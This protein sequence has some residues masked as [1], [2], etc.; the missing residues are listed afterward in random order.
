MNYK[1]DF[2]VFKNRP[3]MIYLDNAASSLKPDVVTDAVA[4][5]YKN[6]SSN[7]ERGLYKTGLEATKIVEETREKVANF[8]GA[9]SNEVIFT[10]GC[11]DSL[12][13]V[14]IS[15][16]SMINEGDE[17]ISSISEHHSSFLPWL[18]VAKEKKAIIKFIPLTADGKIT[19]DNFKT[20]LSSKTKIVA[21]AQTT[22]V[23]GYTAPIKEIARLAHEV[24]AIVS[25]DG[26]Q[27]IPHKRIDVKDLDVDLYSF[28]FH[29]M[30]GPTG[31]GI[32]YGKEKVLN[33]M[34]PAELGGEMNDE[35][36]LSS[37][38]YKEIP[39]KFEAGTLPIAEIFGAGACIDYLSKIGYEYIEKR[40]ITLAKK[41]M[42]ELK[43]IP[44]IIIYN[45]KEETPI[46]SFNI[47]G[48]HS[49]DSVSY[50]AEHDVCMRAG[51]HCAEPFHKWLDTN[52]SLR[53]SFYFYNDENDVEAFIKTTKEAIAFF[54][55]VGYLG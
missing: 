13:M 32:L 12:N 52:A 49:H 36:S 27:A 44:E 24:K 11:T 8:I 3:G 45:D 43:K 15:L 4:D 28:S 2:S 30:C 53:A 41:A 26:A 14:A 34:E 33:M 5:Y 9:N 1:N 48:I 29:K 16:R 51:L 21:I 7:I 31:L 25:I 17:I 6:Y 55:E 39:Y 10:R 35:V 54:K 37:V 38:T 19:I 22:N 20:V 42:N 50:Y 46:I 40:G 47:K 18:N 23:Y